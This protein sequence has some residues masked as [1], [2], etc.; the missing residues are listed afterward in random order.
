MLYTVSF[1]KL[2]ESSNLVWQILLVTLKT[3]ILVF[4]SKK[5][6]TYLLIRLLNSYLTSKSYFQ[7]LFNKKLEFHTSNIQKLEI[8]VS[9][10]FTMEFYNLN[11]FE[12]SI[13]YFS[14]KYEQLAFYTWPLITIVLKPGPA[15]RV[16]PGPGRSRPGTGPGLSKNPSGSQPGETRSTR[17]NPVET[18]PFIYIYIYK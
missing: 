10:I 17:V 6:L 18:R 13:S 3:Y 15:R 5:K 12:I 16:D 9:P 7:Q 11:V 4:F 8:L 2:L 14:F 1:I